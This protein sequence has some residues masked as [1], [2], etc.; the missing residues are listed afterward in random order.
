MERALKTYTKEYVE[1]SKKLTTMEILEFLDNYTKV[2]AEHYSDDPK[3]K[4]FSLDIEPALLAAFQQ[5]AYLEG[6]DPEKLIKKL[7]R[8]WVIQ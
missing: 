8:D 7:M 4:L 6:V 2:A 1:R 5:K 3:C